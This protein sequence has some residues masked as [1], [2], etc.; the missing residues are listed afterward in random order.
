MNYNTKYPKTIASI[1]LVRLAKI[2][3]FL[4]SGLWSFIWLVV[5]DSGY[6]L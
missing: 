4:I 2:D 1:W 3:F 6:L 5:Y